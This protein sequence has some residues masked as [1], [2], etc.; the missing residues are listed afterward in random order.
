MKSRKLRLSE[1]D[2]REYL[3][4]KYVDGQGRKLS[5]RFVWSQKDFMKYTGM[6]KINPVT[7]EWDRVSEGTIS[8]YNKLLGLSERE[9]FN[10]HQ[11]YTKK[12]PETTTFDEWSRINNKGYSREELLNQDTIKRRMIKY[13]GLNE[14]YI[15]YSHDKVREICLRLVGKEELVVFYNSLKG[16]E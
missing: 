10:Y 11:L 14:A 2:F 13:F 1:D 3:L 6:F 12:I 15:H 8:Y 7:G 5:V 16:G 4:E 9:I